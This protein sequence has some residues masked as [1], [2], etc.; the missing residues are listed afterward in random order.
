[1]KIKQ[2]KQ[3]YSL[4]RSANKLNNDYLIFEDAI[5]YENYVVPNNYRQKFDDCIIRA[6]NLYKEII[7]LKSELFYNQLMAVE[8]FHE[9][10]KS[11][12]GLKYSLYKLIKTVRDND[13]HPSDPKNREKYAYYLVNI[14]LSHLESIKTYIDRIII[15]K[16]SELTETE[17]KEIAILSPENLAY[18]IKNKKILENIYLNQ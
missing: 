4:F 6:F 16:M 1:M 5:F 9:F 10:L 7:N 14:N 13:Q 11:K 2:L 12:D 17:K 15:L 3:L 8:N 18:Y